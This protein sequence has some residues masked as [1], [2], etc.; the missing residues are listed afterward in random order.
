MPKVSICIPTYNSAK[1]LP[2][3]IESVLQQDF[4]DF[5]L[6]ICDDASTDETPRL[7]RSLNDLRIRYIRFEENVG[8]AGNFNRCFQAAR[9][10]ILTL[11]SADDYFLPGLLL[12]RVTA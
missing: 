1:Y 4:T 9:G 12:N 2:Q 8:Q 7:C 11:L 3:A 5:E 6:I 10:D